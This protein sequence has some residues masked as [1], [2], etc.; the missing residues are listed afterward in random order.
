MR[1]AIGILLLAVISGCDSQVPPPNAGTQKQAPKIQPQKQQPAVQQP[2][3]PKPTGDSLAVEYKKEAQAAF[4]GMKRYGSEKT[5]EA[6]AAAGTHILRALVLA[7]QHQ[8]NGHST[9]SLWRYRELRQLRTD[10]NKSMG[11]V[12]KGWDNDPEYK[13][14]FEDY[15]KQGDN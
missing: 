6:Y 9:S 10:W 1:Y 4:D 5:A 2:T 15:Q 11:G 14:A 3:Q 13:A 7:N 8:K 12:P